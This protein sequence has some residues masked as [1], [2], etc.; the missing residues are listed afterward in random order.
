MLVASSAEGKG[1]Q[2]D[3]IAGRPEVHRRDRKLMQVFVNRRRVSEYSLIQAAEYGFSG[4]MPGGWYPAV[5]VFVEIDPRLIDFNIHPAKREVRFQNMAEVHSTVV[6]AVRAGLP[7]QEQRQPMRQTGTGVENT[8][9]VNV[10]AG[11][12]HGRTLPFVAQEETTV[13]SRIAGADIRFLGQVFGV[14]LVFQHYDRLLIMDQ[15]AAHERVIFDRLVTQKPKM[16]EMLFPLSFDVSQEDGVRLERC[17]EELRGLGL[18]LSREG[19]TSFEI[20][21]ISEDLR[22]LPEDVLVELVRGA[23]VGEWRS[24]LLATAA[25]RLAI[26]DGDAVDAV[27]AREL[28]AQALQLVVPRCPHGRPIWH[29]LSEEDL[30]KFVDR[31]SRTG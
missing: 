25:C 3:V 18:E 30:R 22:A 10:I 21:A 27:T 7:V 6:S 23:G 9:T 12:H 24:A 19:A 26:K 20:S 5:F 8:R 31:P 13:A 4:F 28:C 29:V 14:F 17:R 2:V 15:H 16:Q 11:V 1:F